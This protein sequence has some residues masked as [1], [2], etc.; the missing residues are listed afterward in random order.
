MAANAERAGQRGV[1]LLV[2]LL[3]IALLTLLVMEFTFT[4][5]VDYRRAAHWLEARQALLI[6]RS[7]IDL[8][9]EILAQAELVHQLV[10]G[11]AKVADSLSELWAQPCAPPGPDSCP[12]DFGPL[13]V[14]DAG[15]GK[16]ALRITDESGLYNLNRLARASHPAAEREREVFER[17][18]AA[19]GVAPQ[20]LGP[21][22][23]WI[24]RDERPFPFGSGAESAEYA[25]VPGA[26]GPRNGPFRTFAEVALV[27]GSSAQT[28]VRL[29]RLTTV[30]EGEDALS[31]NVNTAPLELLAALDPAIA[32]LLP[33][34]AEERCSAPFESVSD[35]RE[36]VP[37]WPK[38]LGDRWV[39]FRS[40]WFRIRATGIVGEVRQSAEALVHREAG[41]I[42]VVYYR[43]RR[44]VNIPQVEE[45]GAIDLE[46][47]G[48]R[49]MGG[50]ERL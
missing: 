13:C 26:V 34:L 20:L 29:R 35:L 42:R 3:A 28:L 16:V 8:G 41:T 15:P 14:I 44:G 32:P 6:A 10:T 2:A 48:A 37:E 4:T 23:D 1:V 33:V 49:A 36:R 45:A 43:A 12:S 9:R 27:S 50:R 24:D 25:T 46:E 17:I 39:R 38:W 19:A 40:D 30:L 11:Q 31:I 47:L 7:G 21:L 22:A 18:A 5:Q